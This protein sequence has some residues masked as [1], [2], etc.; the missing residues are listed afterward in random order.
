MSANSPTLES[1]AS[2]SQKGEYCQKWKEFLFPGLTPHFVGLEDGWLSHGSEFRS[3]GA[4]LLT[5][6]SLSLVKKIKYML[7]RLFFLFFLVWAAPGG[8]GQGAAWMEWK[9]GGVFK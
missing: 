1:K 6:F 4:I 9:F 5:L 8:G 7:S 2:A 3:F